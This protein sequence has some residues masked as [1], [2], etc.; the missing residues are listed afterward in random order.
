VLQYE[1]W[2]LKPRALPS[3]E[4]S[5]F[6]IVPALVALIACLFLSAC[7]TLTPHGIGAGDFDTVVVDAGHGGHDNGA[8]ACKG[9]HEKILSLDIARRLS[10]TL[11]A[12]GLRV[13]ET[14]TGDYFVPLDSRVAMSNQL[15]NAIF[16][17]IHLN[18]AKRSRASGVETYFYSPRASRLAANIQREITRPY[19]ANSRGVKKARFYVLRNNKLPAVLVESGFVSNPSENRS[20]QNPQIRQKIAEAVARGILTE[21]NSHIP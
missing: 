10:R 11:R 20:L 4:Q 13:I 18:W 7:E 19:G 5:Y 2:V 15:R 17:S 16:V 6:S 8:R 9:N 12:S 3:G 14:R 21:K 1:K